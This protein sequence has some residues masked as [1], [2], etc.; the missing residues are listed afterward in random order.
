MSLIGSQLLVLAAV[1]LG[2]S[3]ASLRA[4]K[5]VAS[6]RPYKTHKSALM[7]NQKLKP[8]DVSS[9]QS[10]T[11][12]AVV[13]PVVSFSTDAGL[14]APMEVEAPPQPTARSSEPPL[15][16]PALPK[17]V[18]PATAASDSSPPPSAASATHFVQKLHEVQQ[19][20]ANVVQVQKTLA[21][22]VALLR[23]SAVLVK[24]SV[25]QDSRNQANNQVKKTEAL[26]KGTTAMLRE[27]RTEAVEDAKRVLEEVAET[28]TQLDGL[29]KEATDELQTFAPPK[30]T[31]AVATAPAAVVSAP[32]PVKAHI[33]SASG[34]STADDVDD[35]DDTTES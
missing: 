26:V 17:E 18:V 25:S 8:D 28:Q 34:D 19:R 30:A 13:A 16:P 5:T 12:S 23:E 27:S 20:R 32:H 24:T 7:L 6:L 2:V 9:A 14:S 4:E 35:L 15:P 11:K 22:E 29:R 21:A 31:A 33:L 1:V 10:S 3:S